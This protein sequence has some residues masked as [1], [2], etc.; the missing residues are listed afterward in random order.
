VSLSEHFFDR[1]PAASLWT[2]SHFALCLRALRC[3]CVLTIVK[4][5]SR[6]ER[7]RQE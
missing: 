5:A 2:F 6:E 4:C 3:F 1:G 7:K